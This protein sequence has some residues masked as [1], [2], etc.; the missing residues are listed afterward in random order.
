MWIQLVCEQAVLFKS[1][2]KNGIVANRSAHRQPGA[3]LQYSQRGHVPPTT[4]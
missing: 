1:S 2:S 3:D 4:C